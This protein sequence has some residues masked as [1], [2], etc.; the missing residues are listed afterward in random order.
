MLWVD[1][2]RFTLADPEELGIETTDVLDEP[3]PARD[4]PTGHAR[5]RVVV[6]V[7]VPSVGGDLGDQVVAAQQRLPQQFGGVDA[8][9]QPTAHPNHRNRGDA[10]FNHCSTTFRM[11]HPAGSTA[12][13]VRLVD[14]GGS[15]AAPGGAPPRLAGRSRITKSGGR[16]WASAYP[17]AVVAVAP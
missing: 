12:G 9:R 13:S 5:L 10:S 16:L 4:R 11:H 8:A 3:A 1:R 14:P 6:L 15:F 17:A 7:D 2:R